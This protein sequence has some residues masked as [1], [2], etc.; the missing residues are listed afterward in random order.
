[1]FCNFLTQR[2]KTSFHWKYC[3]TKPFLEKYVHPNT[4]YYAG[5]FIFFLLLIIYRLYDEPD[6]FLDAIVSLLL[7]ALFY[8]Y[9]K[10]FHQDSLSWFFVTF[11]ILLHNLHLY[12]TSPLGIRFDHYMHFIAGFTI[13][14]VTDR[15]LS[16][17]LPLFK[18]VIVLVLCAL[19]FGAI[20]DVVEW[21]GYGILGS[22][23]GFFYFGIGDEGEWRNAI[24]DTIFNGLGGIT[25]ASLVGLLR[26]K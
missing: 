23:K 2:F 10:M 24:L 19:G 6:L 13:A 3:M 8:H 12:G 9:H 21:L 1:M 25:L 4:I 5:L 20:G 15:L 7:Y 17:R 18:R 22:G 11:T 16:E 26:R 14:L